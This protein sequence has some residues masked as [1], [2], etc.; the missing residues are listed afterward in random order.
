MTFQCRMSIY[1]PILCTFT[2]CWGPIVWGGK[3]SLFFGVFWF[4]FSLNSICL[5]KINM[6]SGYK[7]LWSSSMHSVLRISNPRGK[8]NTCTTVVE[9]TV[10][11]LT[12]RFTCS[13]AQGSQQPI[14]SC[15]HLMM[16]GKDVPTTIQSNMGWHYWPSTEGRL[17]PFQPAWRLETQ[18]REKPLNPF[19]N[20]SKEKIF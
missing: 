5:N 9:N 17:L 2:L 4:P 16:E 18:P 10:P 11:L 14:L 12:H 7:G 3:K 19:Y 15:F 8:K 1:L 6:Y 13:F 20:K